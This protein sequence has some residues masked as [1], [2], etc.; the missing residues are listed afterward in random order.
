MIRFD[1]PRPTRGTHSVLALCA[2][3]WRSL[4]NDH[5][6]A[7]ALAMAHVNVAP[8]APSIERARA[9]HASRMRSERHA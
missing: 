6:G 1:P 8:P 9:L 5:A 2:C 4:A 3:G 7:D